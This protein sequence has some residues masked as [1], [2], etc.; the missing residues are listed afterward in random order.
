M[1]NW[2][3]AKDPISNVPSRVA[4]LGAQ[5]VAGQIPLF[6]ES[7]Y[8]TTVD[9]TA[10]WTVV[11]TASGT[12][13]VSG[14]EMLL[15]APDTSDAASITS[16]DAFP[17]IAGGE[18]ILSATLRMGSASEIGNTRRFGLWADASNYMM[19]VL[20]DDL[21]CCRVWENGQEFAN[22][23]T[24]SLPLASALSYMNLQIR[25]TKSR[26]MFLADDTLVG[27]FTT[28][29]KQIPLSAEGL[30]HVVLDNTNESPA[31][32]TNTMFLNE[33]TLVRSFEVW[34][35]AYLTKDIAPSGEL[36]A[37]GPVFF[38]GV[39]ADP[40]SDVVAYDGVVASGSEVIYRRTSVTGEFSDLYLPG[41]VLC[42]DG[43]F[44]SA[45]DYNAVVYYVLA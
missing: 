17:L 7:C 6:G 23:V 3:S 44:V 10:R 4:F 16:I 20:E 45:S 2:T 41:P 5:S 32:T 13:T 42:N 38:C 27:E 18:L 9:E 19:F 39:V 21:W 15:T 1:T 43:L 40:R 14:G 31:D 33:L 30:F 29:G 11:E 37:R 25:A 36:V 12:V 8:G 35:S 24:I 22:D 28:R 26:V 34:P